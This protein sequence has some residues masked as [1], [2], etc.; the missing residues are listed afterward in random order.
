MMIY[1]DIVQTQTERWT[2]ETPAVKVNLN[3]ILS[4]LFAMAIPVAYGFVALYFELSILQ[5]FIAS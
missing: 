3:S 1:A 5:H 4:I 2:S